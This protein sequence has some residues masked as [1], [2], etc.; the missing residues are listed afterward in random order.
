M[1]KK[2]K[3]SGRSEAVIDWEYVDNLLRSHCTGTGIASLV[4]VHPNTLYRL[5][6]ERNKIS[7]SEY[8]QQ[9]KAEGKEL[10]R[11]KQFSVAMQG[12]KTMMVWLGKQYLDQ[13]DKHDQKISMETKPLVIQVGSEQDKQALSKIIGS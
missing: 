5:C 2:K 13:S 6:E 11:Q 4:G 1:A 8:S 12:D 3:T 10:L 9:K 7:F